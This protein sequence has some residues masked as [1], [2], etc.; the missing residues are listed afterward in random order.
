V[1]S[2]DRAHLILWLALAVAFSPTLFELA[3]HMVA[4]PWARY[5][6]VPLLLLLRAAVTGS[7]VHQ[8][9]RF[10]L[11]LILGGLALEILGIVAGPQ[12]LA[13]LGLPLAIIGMSCLLGR[14]S[15][16]TAML[17]LWIVPIPYTFIH[18]LSPVLD[19]LVARA[20]ALLAWPLIPELM[21]EDHALRWCTEQLW[22]TPAQM[23]LPL[24]A[25]L[26]S[27]GWFH[28]TQSGRSML[29][30]A[31]RAALWGL[32]AF[33]IQ[34]IAIALA[35]LT[36]RLGEAEIGRTWLD[37]GVWI[38]AASAGTLWSERRLRPA[39]VGD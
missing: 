26:S 9:R 29:K 16:P 3:T 17:S 1:S 2:A 19:S 6:V 11:W 28:A 4:E 27:I 22:I 38:L 25:L 36:L 15:I 35:A 33:P 5:A 12:R 39:R 24:A 18:T 20:A 34:A 10:G 13:R 7:T 21:V 37:H 14:P 30:A 31:E 8:A 32:A 23:G